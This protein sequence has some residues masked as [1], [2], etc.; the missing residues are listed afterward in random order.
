MSE[1]TLL[2]GDPFLQYRPSLVAC[3]A[4]AVARHCLDYS[5]M[6]PDSMADTTG[7]RLTDLVSCVNE[8][9]KT[10]VH[11]PDLPEKAVCTKYSKPRWV[12]HEINSVL[13][14]CSN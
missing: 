11:V 4:I 2:T 3:S 12:F 14:P 8:I 13:V 5:E 9:N 6:W 10:H 1:L 7:Y